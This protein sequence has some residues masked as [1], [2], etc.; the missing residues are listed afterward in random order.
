MQPP[1]HTH[2]H[3]RTKDIQGSEHI[4]LRRAASW[5]QMA[6]YPSGL[7]PCGITSSV[8][9][10]PSTHPHGPV[11]TV[12]QPA[13]ST[14]GAR[15][16]VPYR[17]APGLHDFLVVH[18]LLLCMAGREVRLPL[19]S[20]RLRVRPQGVWLRLSSPRGCVR[21]AAPVM[22]HYQCLDSPL[23]TGLSREPLFQ[24]HPPPAPRVRCPFPSPSLPPPALLTQG[25]AP[26]PQPNVARQCGDRF[27]SNHT[28]SSSPAPCPPV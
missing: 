14:Y 15:V 13:S 27:G 24:T 2:T 12:S 9:S 20:A 7:N 19:L 28:L 4:W 8:Y 22:R 21:F 17:K 18:V 26:C 11:F 16:C 25:T 5:H 1:N 10:T 3:T 23:W 6:S